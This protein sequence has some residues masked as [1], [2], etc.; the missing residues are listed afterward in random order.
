MASGRRRS[1]SPKPAPTID[2]RA[3]YASCLHDRMLREFGKALLYA[4]RLGEHLGDARAHTGAPAWRRMFH[5]CGDAVDD[6]LPIACAWARELVQ[7]A[8]NPAVAARRPRTSVPFGQLVVYLLLRCERDRL[9]QLWPGMLEQTCDW[10]VRDVEARARD[11]A[12]AG[13]G[14]PVGDRA[15]PLS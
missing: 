13:A 14:P 12:A 3:A 2:A 1:A 7:A 10:L 11:R 15:A 6:A 9:R 5:G 8:Q 4:L